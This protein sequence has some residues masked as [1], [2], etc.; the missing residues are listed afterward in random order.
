MKFAYFDCFAGASGDMIL[1]ALIDAG[2]SVDI[3]KEELGK[4]SLSGYD[5]SA[6]KGTK[7]GI[8]GTTFDVAVSEDH[9][10]RGLKDVV[11]IIQNS[12]LSDGVKT[13]SQ[14]IFTRLAE[15]EAKIHNT[16]VDKIHFHEVGAVDAIVDVVGAC[17][18][19]EKL[20]IEEVH[21]STIHVGTG[22]LECAHG[23]LPVPPPATLELLKDVP[24]RSSGIEHELVTP[25]GAA[26]L[27]T[28]AKGFGPM[29]AM[30]VDNTGYGLGSRDLEIPNT[31]RVVIGERD[32][33]TGED[34]VQLIETNI[35]DMN[36]Q[37]Y[38]YIIEALF[39][40]GAKDVFLTP[41]VMKKSRPGVILSVLA[42]PEDVEKLTGIIFQ[43]TT[44]L[45]VRISD[46]KKRHVLEREIITVKTE[47]GEA[48]VK[49]R[50]M[51]DGSQTVAPEYDDCKRIA[52]EKHVPI[53][54]V[55]EAVKRAAL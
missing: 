16:S 46:V 13:H 51:K 1:G 49:I 14:G 40:Q 21:V 32:E 19:M 31:L 29:P 47:W 43:E 55:Y 23:T 34:A 5:V 6:K 2:L 10:R 45:G 44:T 50:R 37:F 9:H 54:E 38:E 27:T 22:T 33:G 12:I 7:R 35:D 25:T 42:S 11:A 15:A 30:T 4:L 24:V 18:G 3:L 48:R 26:I 20:G 28:L 36:P 52:G 53:R 17:I 39:A 8:S 41:I